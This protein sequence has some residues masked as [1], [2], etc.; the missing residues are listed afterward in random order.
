TGHP[1]LIICI[2]TLTY[3]TNKTHEVGEPCR[4]PT[5]AAI[6]AVPMML[7]V[8]LYI[9]IRAIS[10]VIPQPI[11][12]KVRNKLYLGT[13]SYALLKS[14]NVIKSFSFFLLATSINSLNVT[15]CSIHPLPT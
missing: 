5:V 8:H 4:T 12:F 15:I 10:M 13:E 14:T 6:V 11:R 3:R 7:L 1:C 9:A 2:I